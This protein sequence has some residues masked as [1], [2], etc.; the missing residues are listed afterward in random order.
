MLNIRKRISQKFHIR[1]KHDGFTHNIENKLLN[2]IGKKIYKSI[3]A[4]QLSYL[5]L[6]GA[7]IMGYSVFLAETNLNL[8]YLLIFGLFLHWFGDGLD[9]KVAVLRGEGKPK[10]GYY[11]DRMFDTL[12][13]TFILLSIHFSQLTLSFSW[14]LVTIF[15]LLIWV[16][17]LL[18]ASVT[19][20]FEMQI[21]RFGG[22][23]LKVM[24]IILIFAITFSGNPKFTIF[25]KEY[26]LLDLIGFA[27]V[28]YLS[29]IF[30]S[31]IYEALYSSRKIKG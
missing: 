28:L 11:I 10:Y 2:Y 22:L 15:I 3:N 5:A 13:I 19:S 12:A 23:E 24:A 9:G 31:L 6:L 8:L 14:L 20:V 29:V 18:K 4:D 17:I 26:L 30:I 27:V 1:K 21:G 16:H 25:R 7:L